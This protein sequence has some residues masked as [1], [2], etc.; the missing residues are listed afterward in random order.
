MYSFL[1]AIIYLIFISLGLPDSL[2]GSAWPIMHLDLAVSISYMGIVTVIISLGTVV[3]SLYS[4]KLTKRFGVGIVTTISIFL[5][6]LSLIGYAFSRQFWMVCLCAIPYGLAAGAIDAAINNYVALHYKSSHMSWLHCFW[7]VGVSISP[8]IMSFALITDRGWN[9]G[10]RIVSYIQII[11]VL[12]VLFNISLFKKVSTSTSNDVISSIDIKYTDI[13]K[14][15]GVKL[16]LFTFFCYCGLEGTAGIWA[17]S[18]LVEARGMDAEI[19]A[20]YAAYFYIGITLGRF[21]SGFIT[22]K[23]GDKN[24]I[25]LGQAIIL[26]G[27]FIMF[28]YPLVGLLLVGLGCA[29][30]Y[31]AI[32]H[33]TPYNFGKEY[34]Q[35]IIGIEMASAYVGTTLMPAIFGLVAEYISID[36]YPIY[37]ILITGTMLF[38]ANRFNRLMKNT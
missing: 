24:M 12:V 20:R 15:K 29:P 14:I 4:D 18:Y 27:G 7:G 30:I 25:T 36:A 32:I 38:T 26:I 31:P 1:L 16:I 11:I 23:L 5:S 10:F 8:Y 3:S 6:A 17:S 13:I 2:I 33:S 34:S 19:A 22:N 35:A 21:I 28:V 9:A 37:L